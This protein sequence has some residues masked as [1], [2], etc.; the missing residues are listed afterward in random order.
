MEEH[1]TTNARPVARAQTAICPGPGAADD[2]RQHEP[3]RTHR[4][5]GIVTGPTEAD[6][7]EI[8]VQDIAHQ[9]EWIAKRLRSLEMYGAEAV[10]QCSAEMAQLA[11]LLA[12]DAE[13]CTGWLAKDIR[14]AVELF[15]LLLA[16]E[17]ER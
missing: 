1:M 15:E 9:A 5:G 10:Q 12:R 11:L 17:R 3:E 7:A 4:A 6:L 13:R 8:L 14:E 16:E 2:H